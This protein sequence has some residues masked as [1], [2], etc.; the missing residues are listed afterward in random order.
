MIDK[1]AKEIIV[2]YE[3]E[4]EWAESMITISESMR[5]CLVCGQPVE[6]SI[7][8]TTAKYRCPNGHELSLRTNHSNN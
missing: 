7:E 5:V 2:D 4:K 1:S 8:G 3:R 6:E